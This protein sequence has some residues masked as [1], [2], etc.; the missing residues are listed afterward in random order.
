MR[1]ETPQFEVLLESAPRKPFRAE[2]LLER[3]A[4]VLVA[5]P[6]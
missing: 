5:A 3:V 6:S 4:E 1:V 2:E